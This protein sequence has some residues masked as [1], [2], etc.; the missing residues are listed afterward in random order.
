MAAKTAPTSTLSQNVE[1]YG[2][3]PKSV[4]YHSTLLVRPY[5]FLHV[6]GEKSP[7]RKFAQS[8][9]TRCEIEGYV[10]VCSQLLSSFRL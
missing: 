10:K 6:I 1:S 3:K 8:H 2:G 7:S 9:H 5:R 4:V